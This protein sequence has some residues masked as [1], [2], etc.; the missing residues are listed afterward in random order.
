MKTSFRIPEDLLAVL[1]KHEDKIIRHEAE[2]RN[3]VEYINTILSNI[4]KGD[5]AARVDL[6]KIAEEYVDVGRNIN[7]MVEY[8]AKNIED[9]Y[10]AK[11][12][13]NSAVS[14]F[15]SVL[16]AASTGDLTQKVDLSQIG[17]EY[18]PI[19]E[20]LNTMIDSLS[21]L[22]NEVA[23]SSEQIKKGI[24][25]ISSSYSQ[26]IQS[27]GEINSSIAQVAKGSEQQAGILD[28]IG[29]NME[30]LAR[31]SMDYGELSSR[32]NKDVVEAKDSADKGKGSIGVITKHTD[33]LYSVVAAVQTSDIEIVKKFEVITEITGAIAEIADQLNILSL[34][35]S[36]EAAR[37]G[38]AGRAFAVVADEIK[39]LST[40]SGE[41]AKKIS[42]DIME[43]KGDI[44][45]MGEDTKRAIE[46]AEKGRSA[47]TESLGAFDKIG[48]SV[49]KSTTSI[50][51]MIE[52]GSEQSEFIDVVNGK[53]AEASG[54]ASEHNAS[55]QTVSAAI[56]EQTAGIE[57]I[58]ST[59]EE[60]T[61]I[62][63]KLEKA[64]KKFKL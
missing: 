28:D 23:E 29:M 17:E 3:A 46:Q 9:L 45:K 37:A 52:M 19:G 18:R 39:S 11:S 43:M 2:L 55:V 35:A 31:I 24:A 7:T 14:S 26:I 63:Y 32:T 48:E 15:G 4:S 22:I 44:G 53:V 13:L 42:K 25:Q 41:E 27:S 34:N 54:I 61:K 10:N 57:Q 33:G 30:R 5:F 1:K 12:A 47:I 16:S 58:S 38:D 8:T 21:S 51:E 60:E 36:I 56:E 6:Q 40:S 62:T 50:A 64:V 49:G 59:V 20:D